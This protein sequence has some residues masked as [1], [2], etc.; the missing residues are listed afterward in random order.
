MDQS[1]VSSSEIDYQKTTEV[2]SMYGFT[3]FSK[4]DTSSR[5]KRVSEKLNLILFRKKRFGR[6]WSFGVNLEVATGEGGRNF[7]IVESVKQGSPAQ[8]SQILVG[9][10]VIAVNGT[11]VA[12]LPLRIVRKIMNSSGDQLVLTVL[13]SNPYRIINTSAPRTCMC[14]PWA[15]TCFPGTC[16]PTWT[17]RRWTT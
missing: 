6:F 17:P 14:R 5:R 16:S 9:D 13:S 4:T 7:F 11:K 2:E 15:G 1:N 10:V 3:G 8:R 12:G